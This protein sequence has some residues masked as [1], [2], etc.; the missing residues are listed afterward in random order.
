VLVCA[1]L[2]AGAVDRQVGP[3]T[4]EGARLGACV[5]FRLGDTVAELNQ[6]IGASAGV[7]E[8][9]GA[10]VGVDVW[11][12]ETRSLWLFAD[13]LQRT[14]TGYALVRNSMLLLTPS[15]LQVVEPP[16]GGAVVPDRSDGV[17]YWP[18]SA[19]MLDRGGDTI[20][21][22]MF[23]RVRAEPDAGASSGIDFVT[24]GPALVV[25]RVTDSGAPQLVTKVELGT[26]DPSKESPE[27]GAAA[28]LDGGW[29]YLYGTSTRDLAGIHGFALRV[30][31]VRPDHATDMSRWRYWDGREWRPEPDDA[32]P[33]ILE[34]GGVSQTLSVWSQGGRWY[35]LSKENEFLGDHIVVWRGDAPQG[36]FG[37][38]RDV[39]DLPCDPNTGELRYMPLAHPGLLPEPGTVVVSYSRNYV[40]PAQV[41]AAPW[42]YRPYFLRVAL[43]M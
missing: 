18:M 10:D 30:A 35:V 1:G 28:A 8:F 41:C 21:Y 2:V 4:S 43:P 29:L 25:F 34:E 26:D 7:P 23:Q 11:L 38:P 22:A 15:C 3:A 5:A 19:W 14:P 24:L 12:S 39:A 13:T 33:L 9:L 42:R 16:R 37:P 32:A 17:G 36:P 6:E 27:W 40:D 20:V 31:R